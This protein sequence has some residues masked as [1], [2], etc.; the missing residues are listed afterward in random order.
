MTKTRTAADRIIPVSLKSVWVLVNLVSLLILQQLCLP[1]FLTTAKSHCTLQ[2][3]F[4]IQISIFKVTRNPIMQVSFFLIGM[5][6]SCILFSCIKPFHSSIS[7]TLTIFI[8]VP[9]SFSYS[10]LP[11]VFFLLQSQVSPHEKVCITYMYMF[12]AHVFTQLC[13]LSIGRKMW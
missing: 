3:A 4:E 12:F 13:F 7:S 1:L 10:S 8:P 9:S 5:Y 11:L 6:S 2:C